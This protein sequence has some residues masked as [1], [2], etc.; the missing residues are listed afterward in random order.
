MAQIALRV[1]GLGKR[2]KMA[3]TLRYKTLRDGLAQAAGRLM[4]ASARAAHRNNSNGAS[5]ESYFWALKDV[6][7]TVKPGEIVGVIGRNGAGKSTLLKILSR[8]TEP[9]EG[10]AEVYGKVGSLLEVGTGFHPELTGRENIYLNGAILGMSRFQLRKKFEEIVEF[11]EVGPFLDSPVKY[12]SNGM[13]VRLAFAVAAHLVLDILLID[14][15]L[16]V[17]DAAFQKKCIGKMGEVVR[18][19]R[20]V[21]FVSHNMPMMLSFCKQAVLIDRGRVA[22]CG[23][24]S[25]IVEQYL[26]RAIPSGSS[27]ELEGAAR[28]GS[29]K[30]RFVKFSATDDEGRPWL[31]PEKPAVFRMVL[32]SGMVSV[33]SSRMNVALGINTLTGERVLELHTHFDA[34]YRD[35]DC[36]LRGRMEFV[37]RTE[38]FPLK[39][40]TYVVTL[41]SDY[42][43]EMC[44][45][46]RDGVSVEVR[47]TDY[48]GTGEALSA[49][50]GWLLLEQRW[51]CSQLPQAFS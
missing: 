19:G 42:N 26:K 37:C 40:G 21:V 36:K 49:S 13:Y 38:N 7:F 1:E 51:Q 33:S 15:V 16:A 20:T 43:N 22:G 29:G 25:E 9:T 3:G 47:E 45:R 44:D 35:Q 11:A 24:V 48:F 6:S 50:Q 32:E 8:I 46:I 14:E 4:R 27:L 18:D 23:E 28:D 17:G 41:Y 31:S 34:G 30:I 39:P 2:Y 12:Y 5:R 10:F